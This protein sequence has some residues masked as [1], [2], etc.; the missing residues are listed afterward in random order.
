MH[1]LTECPAC[2][3]AELTAVD[4]PNDLKYLPPDQITP[5]LILDSSFALCPTCGLLFARNR[6]SLEEMQEYYSLFA[7]LEKKEY[8]VYPPPREFVEVQS[9]FAE[10]VTGWLDRAGVL[11][12]EMRVLNLRCECG[13]I[14][15]RL[16]DHYG[17]TH[18]YGLDHFES[19]CQYARDDFGLPNVDLL[20]PAVTRIPFADTKYELILAN[21]QVTHALRPMELLDELRGL[22]APD[23]V[24]VL[25]NE[26]D[27]AHLLQ[28][29]PAYGRGV[30]NFHK[31][32]LTRG[33]LENMCALA[34]LDPQFIWRD[35]AGQRW[36]SSRSGMML[37]ARAAEPR[38]VDRLPAID[39]SEFLQAADQWRTN[40]ESRQRRAAR[41]RR[42]KQLRQFAKDSVKR[43]MIRR[44]PA[45]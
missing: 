21:H 38:S 19:N 1:S 29:G 26:V 2:E 35:D 22:L 18:L 15:A 34:G 16:R 43:F 11:K 6:E 13:A 12:P 39:V 17:M 4:M 23:G 45:A 36:A 28:S 42:R 24:L 20:D 33:S 5:T 27:H 41:S 31:Q 8:A 14:L 40:F 44:R 7:K 9:R 30:I 37:V 25:F 3:C 10:T 32:L